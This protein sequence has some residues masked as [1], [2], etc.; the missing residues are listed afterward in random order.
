MGGCGFSG[1][2]WVAAWVIW[3]GVEGYYVLV[4]GGVGEAH[5]LSAESDATL[6]PWGTADCLRLD[7][8]LL[9]FGWFY[10]D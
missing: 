8:L 6:I 5:L 10:I 1:C 3:L 9:R 7:Q 2:V 4:H